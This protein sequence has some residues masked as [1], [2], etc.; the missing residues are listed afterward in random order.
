M[1]N[2]AGLT[3]QLLGEKAHT[4]RAHI[5]AFERAKQGPSIATFFEIAYALEIPPTEFIELIESKLKALRLNH[6][7]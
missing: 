7:R 5:S 2:T 1:R 6:K 3:Q 4:D